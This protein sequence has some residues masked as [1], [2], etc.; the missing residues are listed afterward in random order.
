M[1]T[2]PVPSFD[3]NI[4]TKVKYYQGKKNVMSIY[5]DSTKAKEVYSFVNID[6]FFTVYPDGGKLLNK[7]LDKNL[8]RKVWDIAKDTPFARENF[9]KYANDSRYYCKFILGDLP[10]AGIDFLIYDQT[11]ALIQLEVN[12]TIGVVIESKLMAE[13]LKAIHN[14]LWKLI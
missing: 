3:K 10:F 13:G 11:V 6:K 5:L 12:E 4:Q 1:T 14:T 7:A 2:Q 8:T 9:S